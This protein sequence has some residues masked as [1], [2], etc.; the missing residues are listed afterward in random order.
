[1]LS[2]GFCQTDQ[3]AGQDIGNSDIGN[4]VGC[5]TWIAQVQALFGNGVALSVVTGCFQRLWIGVHPQGVFGTQQQGGDGQNA[6]TATVVDN[7]LASEI[8]GIQPLSGRALW[9]DECR[10]RRRGRDQASG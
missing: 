7:L 4:R 5:I 6:G 3:W 2:Q 8:L 10:Y 9:L 1:M